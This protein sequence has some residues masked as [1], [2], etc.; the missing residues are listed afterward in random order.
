MARDTQGLHTA[1]KQER[2]M[3]SIRGAAAKTNTRNYKVPREIMRLFF[4]RLPQ[5]SRLKAFV[6]SS[7]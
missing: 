7:R 2:N 5:P 6:S 3:V 4:Y 1:N